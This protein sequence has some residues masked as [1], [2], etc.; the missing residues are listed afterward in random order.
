MIYFPD[1]YNGM[2]HSSRHKDSTTSFYFW[3]DGKVL[4]VSV[5]FITPHQYLD[6]CL[7]LPFFYTSR[8]F[9]GNVSC[10]VIVNDVEVKVDSEL[11]VAERTR[12]AAAAWPALS[13]HDLS[14]LSTLPELS[15]C[16]QSLLGALTPP[17]GSYL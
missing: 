10:P 14:T 9:P 12:V 6:I 1:A 17:G 3:V 7:N 11:N 15:V 16:D 8:V 13:R 2:K 4:D 5:Y